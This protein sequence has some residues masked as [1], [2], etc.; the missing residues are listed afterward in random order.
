MNPDELFL[1][2]YEQ[3][4]G[5]IFRHCFFRLNA[6]REEALDLTQETFFHAWRYMSSGREIKN[7]RAFLYKIATNLIIDRIRK[8]KSLSLDSLKEIGF[9]P[10]NV[11]VP[12]SA[13]FKTEINQ[14]KFLMKDLKPKDR[15]LLVMRFGEDMSIPE[16]AVIL[17]ESENNISVRLH[18][19]IKKLQEIFNDGKK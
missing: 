13:E 18:R 14:L 9:D 10:E 1:E 3:F 8:K 11:N 7:V 16:I 2:A 15:E 17:D 19:A 5:A 6:S 12:E 4:A